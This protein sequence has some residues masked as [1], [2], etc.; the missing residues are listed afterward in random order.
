MGEDPLGAQ[1]RSPHVVGGE[2]YFH[3]FGGEPCSPALPAPSIVEGSNRCFFSHEGVKGLDTD[4]VDFA[5]GTIA[6]KH[7]RIYLWSDLRI[8]VFSHGLHGLVLRSFSEEGFHGFFT[9]LIKRI[10]L[11]K[12]FLVKRLQR[13]YL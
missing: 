9:F 2:P 10:T 11:H 5:D 6:Y 7:M 8:E 1:R 3:V 12:S 4:C 13:V